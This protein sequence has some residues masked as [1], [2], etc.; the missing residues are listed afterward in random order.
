[1]VA[2]AVLRIIAADDARGQM[3]GR[4]PCPCPGSGGCTRWHPRAP[5]CAP[6]SRGTAQWMGRGFDRG[7][8]NLHGFV[9]CS[10]IQVDLGVAARAANCICEV[11]QGRMEVTMCHSRFSE[12]SEIFSRG[13]KVI[14][15]E[16]V[17]RFSRI[18]LSEGKV[19]REHATPTD[20]VSGKLN[21]VSKVQ[22]LRR[23]YW[24]TVVPRRGSTPS[25]LPSNLKFMSLGKT[26]F[27]F[28]ITVQ[29]LPVTE[30]RV[31]LKNFRFNKLN[32]LIPGR[33]A[34]LGATTR[35]GRLGTGKVQASIS[36][37]GSAYFGIF[38]IC[39]SCLHI[40]HIFA[41]FF[42]YKCL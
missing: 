28:Y 16:V 27:P 15:F 8:S 38:C 6:G 41:Y 3:G 42:A 36:K 30:T 22:S 39:L 14:V 13:G 24:S 20:T 1:M 33:N 7:L 23:H 34:R 40:L 4:S 29:S 9:A 19:P 17:D 37:A 26:K 18:A 10:A 35:R 11:F 25:H 32:Y 21:S 12:F 5:C 31:D 2:L